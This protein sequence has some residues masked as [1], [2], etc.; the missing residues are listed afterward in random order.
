MQHNFTFISEVWC[1]WL[2]SRCNT[3]LKEFMSS[4]TQKSIGILQAVKPQHRELA[5]L[6][7]FIL[8]LLMTCWAHWSQLKCYFALGR[9]LK[10][11]IFTHKK[12]RALWLPLNARGI[13]YLLPPV[14]RRRGWWHLGWD[15]SGILAR[16]AAW[17][18]VCM[19]KAVCGCG[20]C[21]A[22]GWWG[23]LVRGFHSLILWW[24]TEDQT[25]K[26]A[27]VGLSHCF[28]FSLL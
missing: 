8:S 5:I 2:M 16:S 14:F 9:S 26:T 11:Y 3:L 23:S 15:G 6:K 25:E 17:S 19:S 28:F 27:A 22:G 20:P 4:S 1:H 24:H 21:T 7:V 13:A 18:L 10:K 12:D